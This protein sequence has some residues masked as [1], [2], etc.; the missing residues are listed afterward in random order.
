[1]NEPKPIETE[2]RGGSCAPAP[3]YAAWV[4]I[5]RQGKEPIVK[6]CSDEET[7]RRIMTECRNQFPMSHIISLE[8]N[9]GDPKE[10]WAESL[11]HY[12]AVVNA[13]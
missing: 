8:T 10:L 13:A 6:R 3:C 9:P 5:V 7:K 2:T 11:A 12:M 1:M 4:L